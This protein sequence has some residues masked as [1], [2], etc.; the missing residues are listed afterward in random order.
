MK[1]SVR[2]FVIL[3]ILMGIVLCSSYAQKGKTTKQVDTTLVSQEN[4][5]A[6]VAKAF[7]KRFATASN[8]VWRLIKENFVAECTVRDVSTTATFK[9]DGTW[10]STMEELDPSTLPSACEKSISAYFQKYTLVSYKRVTENDKNVTLTVGIYE[11]Q[12]AKKKLETKVLLDKVGAIIR[13]IEPE[14]PDETTATETEGNPADKKQ[15]KQ[16][17]KAK[18]ELDKDKRMDIYPA[19]ISESELPPSLLRWVSLRY[20]EYGYKEI[21][22]TEDAEFEDEG[23][24]YRIKIQRSGVGQSAYATVWFTRDGDFLKVDDPFRT[25]EELE[26]TE[27]AALE[28]EKAN[29]SQEKDNAKKVKTD[30]PKKK[31]E[32]NQPV[33]TMSEEAPE[34]YRVAMKL[35]YPRQ[36]EVTWG[37]DENGNWIAFYTDPAGKNEVF[38]EQTDSVRWLETKTPISDL[39]RVPFAARSYV[40]KNY[41]KQVSIK[42]AWNVKSAKVKPYLIVE[43]YDKKLKLSDFVQFWQT[44]KL[45]E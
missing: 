6:E 18:K 5:P 28:A 41:P 22:Y 4:I 33:I 23:N 30:K 35:K 42:Q 10:L 16:E 27:Q 44:G 36:K 31:Q 32:D 14:E 12:N 43:L 17:A 37:E 21:L 40:E 24:L 15:A 2:I 34:E 8:V 20:P 13:T 26:K 45:K 19:K 11:P 29:A 9:K 38:F 25:E 3:S 1:S 39:N 7:K